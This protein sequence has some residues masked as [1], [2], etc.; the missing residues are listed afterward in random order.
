MRWVLVALAAT[1]SLQARDID[2]VNMNAGGGDGKPLGR[3][4]ELE[5]NDVRNG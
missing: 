1:G 4:P 5:L 3:D 2:H